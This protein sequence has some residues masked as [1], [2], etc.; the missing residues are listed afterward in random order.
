MEPQQLVDTLAVRL[1]VAVELVDNHSVKPPTAA[2]LGADWGCAHQ[3]RVTMCLCKS[4]AQLGGLFGCCAGAGDAGG[5]VPLSIAEDEAVLP[6]GG[7][8]LYMHSIRRFLRCDTPD[9]EVEHLTFLFPPIPGPVQL[10]HA[11]PVD[12]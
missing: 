3:I 4:P 5:D 10:F 2:Q 11:P 9:F 8:E 6:A 12:L 1:S 7:W